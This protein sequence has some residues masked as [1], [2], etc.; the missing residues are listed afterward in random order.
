MRIDSHTHPLAHGETTY[1]LPLLTGFVEAAIQA[2]LDQIG[3]T[4]HDELLGAVD[5]QSLEAVRQLFP[6]IEIRFG[7]EVGHLPGSSEAEKRRQV[8]AGHRFDY[9][10]GSVHQIGDWIFDHPDYTGRYAEWDIDALYQEYFRRVMDAVVSGDYHIIGHLDLI[11]VF[12]YRPR[13]PLLAYAD[14]VLQA[15]RE[16][17]VAIEI[18]TAGLAK[19]VGE[20]YPNPDLL[21][22]AFTYNIPV[23]LGSDA[24]QAGEV[25]RDF[26]LAVRYARKAGYRKICCFRS[27]RRDVVELG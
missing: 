4:D 19:P 7:V 26:V 1:G 5:Y 21:Q 23:T 10:I 14:P 27:G 18:N 11:K 13:K 22:R 24:H 3:F 25:G 12:N 8:L 15:I 20:I 2:D 9:L 6:G 17:G 16:A